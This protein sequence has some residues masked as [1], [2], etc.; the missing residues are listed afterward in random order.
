MTDTPI[1]TRSIAANGWL[2]Y[3]AALAV[4]AVDQASKAWILYGLQLRP[5]ESVRL[6]PILSLTGVQNI[7]VTFGMLR[8]DTA[9]GRGLLSLFALVVVAAL[10]VWARKAERRLMAV[11]LGLVMGGAIGNNLIDRIRLGHVTDFIDV[12]GLG[13]FP[14]VFNVADICI[15]V[16]VGLLLLDALWPQPKPDPAKP[17]SEAGA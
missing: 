6:L 17:A 16:G 2:A 9:L 12:S 14:W 11:A 5:G 13:F 1:P 15:D 8:A 7:G 4:V 3:A 10:G